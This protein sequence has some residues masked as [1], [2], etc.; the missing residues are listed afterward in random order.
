MEELTKSD[1]KHFIEKLTDLPLA[2]QPGTQWEYS[3]STDVLGYLIEV[4]TGQSLAIFLRT[5]IFTPL[6]MKDTDFWVPK[7]K[8]HRLPNLYTADENGLAL[9]EAAEKSRF[10]KRPKMLSGGGGLVSTASDYCR[11]LQMLLNQGELDGTRIMSRKTIQLMLSNHL[12]DIDKNWLSPGVT[13]GLGPAIVQDLEQYGELGSP[14]L[15]FWAGIYNT[16][17]FVDPVEEMIGI[18]MTQMNPFVL[19]NL[20]KRFR[21]LCLQA[22]VD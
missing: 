15:F 16:F 21:K 6:D 22:I 2:S 20:D 14:G 3:Y 9:D 18:L 4:V 13:F 19:H 10:L 1:L 8:M 17:F 12:W 5:H 7:D 11:F